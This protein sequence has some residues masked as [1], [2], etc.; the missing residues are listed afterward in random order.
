MKVIRLMFSRKWILATL[1]VFAGTAVLARLG[2]W[3]LDRLAEQR[4]F[5]AHY[6][7]TSVLPILTIKSAPAED[8]TQMEYRSVEVV[9]TYDPA[10]QVVLRNQYYNDKPGYFLLT[11][12]I[13]SDG[14]AI[15]VE[16]GWIPA[17]GNETPQNQR[18]GPCC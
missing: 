5:N 7:A 14:S 16:R 3:Q 11:P 8:I 10:H 4:A 18:R 1:L 9:G 6:L 13:L 12:L 15:L 2:I 17:I